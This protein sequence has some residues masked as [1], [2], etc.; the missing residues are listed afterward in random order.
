MFVHTDFSSLS[1][2]IRQ[3][4]NM[5]FLE[6]RLLP[7]AIRASSSFPSLRRLWSLASRERAAAPLSRQAYMA[8]NG[9][10]TALRTTV[11]LDVI[12]VH[13][14][15]NILWLSSAFHQQK[16]RQYYFRW[17][18]HYVTSRHVTWL[19]TSEPASP[20]RGSPIDTKSTISS[21]M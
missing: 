15:G 11:L 5:D 6:F 12:A 19:F 8:P 4:N 3:I 18:R 2:F 14:H 20:Y 7:V 10:K 9:A 13:A 16:Q 17:N 1:V 21:S